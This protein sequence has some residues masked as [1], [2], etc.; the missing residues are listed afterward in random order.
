MQ[1]SPTQQIN[2]AAPAVRSPNECA[3]AETLAERSN[4]RCYARPHATRKEQC[5]AP[6]QT[7]SPRK[8][9]M[10]SAAKAR[11]EEHHC[12]SFCRTRNTSVHTPAS[13]QATRGKHQA[14]FI[15]RLLCRSLNLRPPQTSGQCAVCCDWARC[16]SS[17]AGA[18]QGMR[19]TPP[20]KNTTRSTATT[21]TCETRAPT[22]SLRGLT[23]R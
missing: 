23:K 20:L 18:H 10:S 6:R 19:L 16:S 11:L 8:R 2:M 14:R 4:P 15:K 1:N 5:N 9:A 21:E 22:Q 3:S 7:M 17:S 12:C 13:L